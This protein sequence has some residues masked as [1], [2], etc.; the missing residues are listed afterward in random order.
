M[1]V[2]CGPPSHDKGGLFNG[3]LDQLTDADRS[4]ILQICSADYRPLEFGACN[5]LRLASARCFHNDLGFTKEQAAVL[6]GMTFN[7]VGR[8]DL[9]R[10]IGA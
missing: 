4:Y 6:A 3:L 10:T 5:E 8:E 9:R 2:P 1:R 7:M